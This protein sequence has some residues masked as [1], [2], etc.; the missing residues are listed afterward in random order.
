MAIIVTLVI[1]AIYVALRMWQIKRI[2]KQDGCSVI[3]PL[4]DRPNPYYSWGGY[5]VTWPEER[6][7]ES[8]QVT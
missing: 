6:P 5:Y 2:C 4:T 8:E 7:D 1:A 3:V